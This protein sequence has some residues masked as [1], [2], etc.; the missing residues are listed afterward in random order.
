MILFLALTSLTPR[1]LVGDK[2]IR[3]YT[4][5]KNIKTQ[6]QWTC[7]RFFQAFFTTIIWWWKLNLQLSFKTQFSILYHFN[8]SYFC[9]I[10]AVLFLINYPLEKHF[11]EGYIYSVFYPRSAFSSNE[12]GFESQHF[13][14][15]SWRCFEFYKPK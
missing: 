12:A 10:V 6:K 4:T 8:N 1:V 2:Y 7:Q 5:K 15:I 9:A 14:S 3:K 13:Y 11:K